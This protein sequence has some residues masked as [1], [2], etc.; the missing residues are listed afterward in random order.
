ML[1][2]AS[3]TTD[4]YFNIGAEE[5]FLKSTTEDIFWVY[6]NQPAIIVGKHQNAIAEMNVP[7]VYK[8][9]IPVVRRVSGGGTVF[10]DDG[11]LNYAFITNGQRDSLIDF[12]K[13][14]Q[15]VL[16]F[17]TT[18][19]VDARLRGKSDL[20]IN[21]AKFSG[22]AGHVYRNRVM[23]HGT[24][25]YNARLDRLREALK[26]HWECYSDQAV[27][28]NPSH[29]TNI[30]EHLEKPG[31]IDQF[32]HQLMVFIKNQYPG[33]VFY[34]LSNEDIAQI[35]KLVHEKFGLDSWNF[36]YSP[37]YTFNRTKL[38][39]T[40]EIKVKLR[41]TGGIIVEDEI[42]ITGQGKLFEGMVPELKN[43]PHRMEAIAE[44]LDEIRPVLA[45]W[46]ISMD[47][48]T[49]CFF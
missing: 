14:T 43:T 13:A 11:N 7:W 36:G 27:R 49:D 18:L 4:P 38:I 21:D 15:P 1:L 24:L 8:N 20:V 37:E 34:T 29:V 3:P 6:C 32:K 17:L 44:K 9:N 39:G 35:D 12:K 23:H 33:N 41:V 16:D 25:L 31:T 48:L 28:S 46:N 26:V 40:I 30:S 47:E 2:C 42:T 45:E 10:H 5:Y 19:G 22:N